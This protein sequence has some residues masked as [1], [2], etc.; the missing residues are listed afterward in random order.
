MH[1]LK[2]MLVQTFYLGW[3]L[4]VA[5][6]IYEDVCIFISY[7]LYVAHTLCDRKHVL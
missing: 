7:D 4:N 2:S 6:H 1:S 5:F 3:Q